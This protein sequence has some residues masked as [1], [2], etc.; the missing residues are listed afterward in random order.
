MLPLL[1]LPTKYSLDDTPLLGPSR[2]LRR[3]ATR[4]NVDPGRGAILCSLL[5]MLGPRLPPNG[6][7]HEIDLQ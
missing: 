3:F 1:V 2:Q 6:M 4:H 7:L 5:L